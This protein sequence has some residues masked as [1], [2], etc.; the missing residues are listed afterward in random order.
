[1]NKEELA[2]SLQR[3]AL[4][5]GNKLSVNEFERIINDLIN[6]VRYA[7]GRNEDVRVGGFG[8][9]YQSRRASRTVTSYFA[10]EK[11]EYK[12]SAKN[13][14]AFKAVRKTERVIK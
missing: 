14:V 6:S 5:R 3:K 10:N 11:K 2:C 4:S 9:F 13:V 8:K 1:V 12:I 7:L